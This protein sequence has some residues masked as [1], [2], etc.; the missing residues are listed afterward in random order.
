MI[1]KPYTGIGSRS[2]PIAIKQQMTE[3]ARLL[4]REGWTLRTG[5]AQGADT[6][7]MCGSWLEPRHCEVYLPWKGFNE[8][9]EC[10][11]PKPTHEAKVI[12]SKFHP[13]WNNLSHGAKALHAR[14]VHQVLGRDAAKPVLSRFVLCWTPDGAETKTTRETGGTGQA[15]RIAL[16]YSVPVINM[17]NHGWM[18]RL[19]LEAAKY[20]NV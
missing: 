19:E 5:G 6:A 13:G 4:K 7:F 1:Y 16:A 18:D 20:A 14:N 2:T 9:N 17:F 8:L 11:L 10:N 15:I 12:A 3:T